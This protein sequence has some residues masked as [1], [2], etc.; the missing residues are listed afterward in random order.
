M[1]GWFKLYDEVR[2]EA[3][4]KMIAH[5]LCISS[6][7][8]RG[9][10]LDVL[11]YA[12][13]LDQE[14]LL[15]LTPG[16]PLSTEEIAAEIGE[17]PDVARRFIHECVGLD[18]LE[19]TD[20]G[21]GSVYFVTSGPRRQSKPSDSPEATRERKRLERERKRAVTTDTT[22]DES[23][24]VTRDTSRH[25]EE[26]VEEEVEVEENKEP[27]P[28]APSQALAPVENLTAD[29]DDW[30][31]GY[32]NKRERSKALPLYDWHRRHGAAHTDLLAARDNYA[33]DCALNDRPVKYAATFL[34]RKDPPWLDFLEFEPHADGPGNGRSA[35][36]TPAE[37][38]RMTREEHS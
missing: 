10:W 6:S 30:W 37:I 4:L 3:K 25:T 23:H 15:Q 22:R 14:W 28:F 11:C 21:A 24:P 19:L 26:E 34:A 13:E 33:A 27:K 20:V 31:S 1:S 38:F 18:M 8:A 9:M 16:F 17:D 7:T 2:G 29:F 12:H 32:P 36:L 35:G 5:R